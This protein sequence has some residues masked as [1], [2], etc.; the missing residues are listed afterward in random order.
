ME[1]EAKTPPT[2]EERLTAVESLMAEV[3]NQE[4]GQLNTDQ[5]KKL[6]SLKPAVN[7]TINFLLESISELYGPKSLVRETREDLLV[8][9]TGLKSAINRAIC[10][11]DD[12]DKSI[13]E[14]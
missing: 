6:D 10:D 13:L 9:L 7:Q 12:F 11:G 4:G 14:R 5:V 1:N 8:V 3:Q 2:N